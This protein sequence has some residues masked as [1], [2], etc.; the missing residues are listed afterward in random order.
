MADEPDKESKTEEATEKKIRDSIE[1]GQV[2]FAREVPAFASFLAILT[3]ML[4]FAQPS[5]AQL[6]MFLSMFMER[7]DEWRL[8]TTHDAIILQRTVFFEI[9]KVLGTLMFLLMLAGISASVLQN[10][11][12]FVLDRIK[13]KVSRISLKKGWNRL[14]GK[15]G[16]V[17]FAKSIGKILIV[18]GILVWAMREAQERLLAGM[19]THPVA[20]T[21][22]IRDIGV[23]I[24]V[25]IAAVMVVIAG[26]DLLWSRFHWREQLRMTRQ[27]V[28]D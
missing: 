20:F 19:L 28:K 10:V 1:K 18:G 25:T 4:F 27:E 21:S 23:E 2:P 22:V 8:G 16:L 5:G 9:A 12:R 14:F 13:P 3:F 15:Q 7:A 11:P 26:A 6:G 17:E 24:V